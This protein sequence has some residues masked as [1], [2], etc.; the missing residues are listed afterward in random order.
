M[1]IIDA[2]IRLVP[3]VLGD[4]N[5]SRSD[6]F[7]TASRLLE[8]AQYTRPREYRGL[9]VPEILLSGDHGGI[10]RSREENSRQR[11]EQW[12]QRFIIARKVTPMSHPL[13]SVVEKS[14]LKAE[15]SPFGIGDTVNVHC[16][17]LEGEK[18]RTQIYTGVVIARAGSGSRE[19]FTVRRIVQGEGV[20]RKFPM[21]SPKSARST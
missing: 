14:S 19:T 21:H 3:G 1:V 20:E 8:F 7:S 11:T 10:A 17:I 13:L 9:Q 16:R 2:V 15:V 12:Q 4:A 18:Q 5:S 6:S